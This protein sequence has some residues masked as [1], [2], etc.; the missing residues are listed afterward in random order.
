MIVLLLVFLLPGEPHFIVPEESVIIV[1]GGWL[2][3]HGRLNRRVLVVDAISAPVHE[4]RRGAH[5]TSLAH[6][7]TRSL[8]GVLAHAGES[9]NILFGKAAN[10]SVHGFE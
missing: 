8:C 6:S 9:C 3:F 7:W 2:L 10:G 1:D 5:G 4:Q